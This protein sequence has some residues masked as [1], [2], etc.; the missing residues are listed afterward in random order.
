MFS[1]VEETVSLLHY[2]A[3]RAG[4]APDIET[5]YLS[6]LSEFVFVNVLYNWLPE[7]E[8][9]S[10]ESSF[11]TIHSYSH[12]FPGGIPGM[13]KRGFNCPDIKISLH[14]IKILYL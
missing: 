6:I 10:S 7:C 2:D 8:L 13:E 4:K 11:P 12:M 9:L 5:W 1:S 3:V 14:H